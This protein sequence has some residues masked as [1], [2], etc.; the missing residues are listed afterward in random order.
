MKVE[1]IM[2]RHLV[3]VGMDDT[4]GTI[5]RLFQKRH[6]HHLMV[7]E[8]GQLMGVISDRD[9][10]KLITPT[11]EQDLGSATEMAVLN[12]RA[13]TI[14]TRKPVTVR[15]DASLQDAIDRFLDD[16]VSCLPVV[17]REGVL[18]GVLSWKD[19]LRLVR[20][21]LRQVAARR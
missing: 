5:R 15:P 20:A 11:I 1:D 7:V 17:D 16:K 10:L 19:V 8:K 18:R 14:M 13:H 21:Q 12:R 9:Y 3:T 2:S 6:F 4:L